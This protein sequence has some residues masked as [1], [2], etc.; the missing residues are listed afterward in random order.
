MYEHII[1]LQNCVLMD[2]EGVILQQ[3]VWKMLEAQI[4][5]HVYVEQMVNI[6]MESVL[7]MRVPYLLGAR[8]V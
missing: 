5:T 2:K 7:V 1:L 8:R 3:F 6:V 4:L